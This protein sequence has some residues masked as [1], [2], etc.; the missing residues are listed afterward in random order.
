MEQIDIV[1]RATKVLCNS[2]DSKEQTEEKPTTH[3]DDFLEEITKPKSEG[4]NKLPLGRTPIHYYCMF[5]TTQKLQY[6][7]ECTNKDV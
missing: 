6:A 2:R 4:Y 3:I 1:Y 7:V 5:K